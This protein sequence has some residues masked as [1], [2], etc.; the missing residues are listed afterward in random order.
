MALDWFEELKLY[1]GGRLPT[2]A[3]AL[4]RLL[5]ELG[6]SEFNLWAT[7]GATTGLDTGEAQR[8][9]REALNYRW[10]AKLSLLGA[11]VSILGAA[12]AWLAVFVD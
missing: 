1:V 10:G 4:E 3:Q 8:R 9:I 6:I 7:K 2:D 5:Q 12:A 11:L